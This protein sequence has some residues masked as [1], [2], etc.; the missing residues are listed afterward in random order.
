M[1]RAR[2]AADRRLAI[3]PAAAQERIRT[4][5]RA[6][7]S[8]IVRAAPGTIEA[9]RGG[10]IR[11]V[12][13]AT[14]RALH[15]TV[16]V[17]GT[18]TA[19][20]IL[21]I[22][23]PAQVVDLN[24]SPAVLA[25]ELTDMVTLQQACDDAVRPGAAR[26][27][28]PAL[29]L[30]TDDSRAAYLALLAQQQVSSRVRG[31][32]R[33]M[34]ARP[35]LT[36]TETVTLTSSGGPAPLTG[37]RLGG[38]IDTA[39]YIGGHGTAL[40]PADQAALTELTVACWPLLHGVHTGV[41]LADDLARAANL[42][43]RQARIRSAL[44]VRWIMRC[45]DCRFDKIVNPEYGRI[46]K[47]NHRLRN[48][49]GIGAAAIMPFATVAT[50]G[51]RVAT[52]LTFEPDY[53]CP[54]CQGLDADEVRAGICPHCGQLRKEVILGRC[55]N[56]KCRHDLAGLIGDPRPLLPLEPTVNTHPER[57]DHDHTAAPQ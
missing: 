46:A 17:V 39:A 47:R 21:M 33:L 56:E 9:L 34:P 27:F 49:I 23:R 20:R 7:G 22:T 32:L 16:T 44:A 40:P 5:L 12:V 50:V 57:T 31:Q 1:Q 51:A 36:G 52:G 26:P 41:R 35:P 24:A 14:D 29:L 54:R 18:A 55:R 37:H 48:A 2:L 42:A 38:L 13:G 6:M 25:A 11:S 19:S 8:R 28:G 15:T 53:V 45:Q 4:A 3:A 43:D 10:R 30:I